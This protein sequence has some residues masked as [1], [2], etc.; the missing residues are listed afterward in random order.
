M[1]DPL[2]PKTSP[3]PLHTALRQ[4]DFTPK[5]MALHLHC[6]AYSASFGLSFSKS[7]CVAEAKVF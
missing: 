2:L 5:R 1:V 7:Q 4:W 3:L 6:N